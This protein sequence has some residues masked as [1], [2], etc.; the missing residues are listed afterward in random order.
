LKVIVLPSTIFVT[1]SPLDS[2][3]LPTAG[4]VTKGLLVAA[5]SPRA[6]PWT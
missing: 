2:E 1:V 4:N 6:L 3:C 5:D